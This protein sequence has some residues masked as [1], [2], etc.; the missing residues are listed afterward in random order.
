MKKW[1]VFQFPPPQAT[2]HAPDSDKNAESGNNELSKHEEF[3]KSAS[4]SKNPPPGSSNDPDPSS[5]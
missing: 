5:D 4:E 2:S 1:P 3:D